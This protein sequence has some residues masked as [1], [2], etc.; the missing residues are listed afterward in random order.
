MAIALFVNDRYLCFNFF[1]YIYVEKN[2]DRPFLVTYVRSSL[3]FIYLL[4]LCFAPPTRDPCRPAD[5]TVS[6]EHLF[7]CFKIA[8]YYS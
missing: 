8:E 2:L 5:Y 7:L 6:L 1:Q 3:L 4:V